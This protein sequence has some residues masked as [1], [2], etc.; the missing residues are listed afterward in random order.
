[1]Q[2]DPATR[3]SGI[4]QTDGTD[5]ITSTTVAGGRSK[6]FFLTLQTF[7]RSTPIPKIKVIG[8]TA[9]PW[10]CSYT[11]RKTGPIVLPRPLTREVIIICYQNFICFV[12]FS[13]IDAAGK[14]GDH[15]LQGNFLWLGSYSYCRGIVATQTN[16]KNETKELYKGQYCLA[17]LVKKGT[18]V[19]TLW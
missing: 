4:V 18:K 10:K 1:M 17:S 19:S 9:R 12:F 16:E 14:P 8:Q 5:S 11:D 6:M 3:I 2:E 15:V 7:S 13:V